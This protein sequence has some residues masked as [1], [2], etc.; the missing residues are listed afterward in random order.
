MSKDPKF[1]AEQ[2]R[3]PSGTSATET[4]QQMN[5][6]NKATNLAALKAL[7]VVSGDCVLEIGPGN[8]KFAVNVLRKGSYVRYTGIDWSS[9]MVANAKDLNS[10]YVESG[11][12]DFRVGSSESLPFSDGKFDKV[13]AV[14]TIYFW[15]VLQTHL[16]EIYRVLVPDGKLC[17][18]FADKSF[19]Q[20]LPFTQFGFRLFDEGD[21]RAELS[22]AGFKVI[23]CGKHSE[24][25][26]NNTK[27]L[28]EKKINIIVCEPDKR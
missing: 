23:S 26:E 5:K 18:A 22:D 28:V 21:I 14:H 11:Q 9:D 7:N 8:G 6:A 20:N 10:K 24:Y 27:Q 25:G 13:I 16:T 3:K 4:A 17:L 12:M 19:M 2:L 1:V 15:E